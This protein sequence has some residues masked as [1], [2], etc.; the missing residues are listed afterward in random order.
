MTRIHETL[1][2]FT[3]MELNPFTLAFPDDREKLFLNDFYKKSILQVRISFFLAV[4]LYAAFGFLDPILAKEMGKMLWV[5]RFVVMIPI[6]ALVLV[7]SYDK[8]FDRYRDIAFSFC[9]ILY[10]LGI[11][12]MIILTPKP[13]DFA[14]YAALL[15]TFIF[16]YTFINI[17]FVAATLTG[18]I[19][20]ICY[21]FAAIAIAHTPANI[22]MKN[23][24]FFIS[25]NLIGMIVAYSIEFYA[26][27]DFYIAMVLKKNKI[28]LGELNQKLEKNVVEKTNQIVEVNG[29]LSTEISH[30]KKAEAELLDAHVQLQNLYKSTVR[31]LVSA[32]ETRDPYTAGHQRKVAQL[33][34]SIALEMDL[35][36]DKVESIRIAAMVHD[37]GKI[38]V[39]AEILSKPGEIN[40]LEM[41]ILRKHS[42]T[43][44][45]I[46][47]SVDFPWPV[48]NIVRQH[49]ERLDGSGYPDHLKGDDILLES[50]VVMVADVVEA[51]ATNRPYRP[52]LGIQEALMELELNKGKL[53]NEHAV[54]SCLSL[55][56]SKSFEFIEEVKN[57]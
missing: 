52:A 3:Q 35:S 4:M 9:M 34:Q 55:F 11:I 54:E 40:F 39:P 14:Y 53:Y 46:L 51:M 28:E 29:T 22:I 7:T 20:L 19:I 6:G 32:I 37:I 13:V 21:E 42:S 26:R 1:P 5:I 16:V 24:F 10:G 41:D 45:D 48:A 8:Q 44:A 25:T 57:Y 18:V 43:G 50:Q 17:R 15:I 31:G 33:A 27:R 12:T 49:H 2:S 23:N 38:S 30:R 36:Q 47:E 56:K